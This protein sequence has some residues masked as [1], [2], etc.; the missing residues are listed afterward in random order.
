[1]K[2]NQWE[3]KLYFGDNLLVLRNKDYFPDESVDLIYL[4]PPFNSK[5][6]YNVLFGEKDGSQ[7]SSQITAF[8]DTWHWGKESA[9][10]YYA[11][12][13]DGRGT[14]ALADLMQAFRMFLG[15]ND[16]MAYLVM[17]APRLVELCRVLKNTGSIY[18][19][20]DDVASHYLKLILDSIFGVRNYRN[21]IIWQRT[22]AH[23]TASRYGRVYDV[24]FFYTKTESYC[25]NPIRLPYSKEQLKRYSI[26]ASGRFY[27]GQ[28]LTASRPNS[29]SGKFEWRGTMPPSNRGWGYKLE[30]LEEWWMQGRILTRKDGTPRMDGLTVYLDEMEGK[31][32]QALWTDVSRIP[33][34]SNERLGYPTQK[35]EALLERIINASSN[36][37]DLVL[38]PFCGCGTTVAVAERLKRK[39]TGIDITHL[40]ITL[41]KNRIE[42]RFSKEELSPYEIIGVPVDLP[43][44]Q[45][46]ALQDRY[47]FEWWALSLIGAR[48][49]QDKKKGADAG[50]DGYLDFRDDKSGQIKKI[51]VQVK[52]GKVGTAQVRDLKGV[53]QREKAVIGVFITLQS[54]TSEMIREANTGKPE[55]YY[56]SKAH[57]PQYKF[58]KIQV[59]TIKDL[60]SGDNKLEY[61]RLAQATFKPAE[62]RHK[63]DVPKQDELL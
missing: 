28:D 37:G 33:N 9:D 19:H 23:N 26:D 4:D 11:I 53:V 29:N 50:I 22:N 49:A 54:P 62:R 41:M 43:S 44:A 42:T 51:V 12:V 63:E 47:Q 1:M 39:W 16:M 57:G 8:G 15:Q 21:Q 36:E 13:E 6:T 59:L 7:S 38:D 45:A 34:T 10:T 58:P 48:P 55:D 40:A 52:S 35:P 20:C 27:T 17:M 18:V 31:P 46:L 2:S 30:Q 14:K 32:L 60:L 5:A 25:W 56:V 3:N 61:P 24:I